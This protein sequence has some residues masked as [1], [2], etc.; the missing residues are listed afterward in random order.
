MLPED[1]FGTSCEEER[2]EKR[3]VIKFSIMG[4][5]RGQSGYFNEIDGY[6]ATKALLALPEPPT[7]IF[8]GND[9]QA[10]GVYRALHE[11]GITVPGDISVIGFDNLPFTELLSPPLTTIHAPRLELGRT[12]AAMLLRLIKEETIEMPRVVLPTQ[13]IERQSCRPLL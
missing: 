7:A 13:F 2:G 6:N 8:A 11:A 12:A 1:V 10:V 5:T 9:R 3:G 4:Q